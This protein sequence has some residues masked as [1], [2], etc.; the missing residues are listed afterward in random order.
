MAVFAAFTVVSCGDEKDEDSKEGSNGPD[1]CKCVNEEW[2]NEDEEKAC[3]ELEMEWKD[4][5]QNASE[6]EKEKMMEQ[7]KAC[8]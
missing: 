6:E 8:E 7:I 3:K 5:F 1:V 2:E 4:K